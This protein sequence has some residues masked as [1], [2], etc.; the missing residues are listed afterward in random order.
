MSSNDGTVYKAGIGSNLCCYYGS[1]NM[2]A[3]CINISGFI[4]HLEHEKEGNKQQ[5]KI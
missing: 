3:G 4:L 2:W 5:L 1:E